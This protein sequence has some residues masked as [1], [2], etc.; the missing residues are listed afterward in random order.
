M[1]T[2]KFFSTSVFIDVDSEKK[3]NKYLDDYQPKYKLSNLFSK[4]Y[5]TVTFQTH[6]SNTCFR[7][8]NFTKVSQNIILNKNNIKCRFR[9]L[10]YL[11]VF[12]FFFVQMKLNSSLE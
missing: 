2:S 5:F 12:K 4:L 6:D 9:N 8:I 7:K 1:F 10:L 11:C 3:L